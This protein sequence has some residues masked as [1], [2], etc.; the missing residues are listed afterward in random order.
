[1]LLSILDPG[2]GSAGTAAGRRDPSCRTVPLSTRTDRETAPERQ[3]S[4]L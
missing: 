4:R 3:F 2:I 1:M